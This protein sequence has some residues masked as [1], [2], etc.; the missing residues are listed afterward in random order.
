MKDIKTKG[1]HKGIETNEHS[2]S[3]ASKM[4]QGLM[5]SG[6][7]VKNYA[8]DGQ[9]TPD[10][11]AQDNVRYMAEKTADDI[12]H[13][14]ES[15]A[16]KTYSAGKKAIS[17]IKQRRMDEKSIKQTAKSTGKA[18]IKTVERNIKTAERAAVQKTVK[19]SEKAAKTAYQT[20]KK[21]EKSAKA[22]AKAAKKS[23]KNAKKAAEKT[24]EAVKVAAK[25]IAAVV[26]KIYK[27]LKAL[28]LLIAA[29]GWVS[30]VVIV[31]IAVIAL[32]ACTGYGIFFTGEEIENSYTL[33]EAV[34]EINM[35]YDYD[36]TAIL[37]NT[38]YDVVEMRGDRA[39]WRD[40][41]AV[42]AVKTSGNKDDPQE[43]V[44]MDASKSAILKTVFWDM[45]HVEYRTEV[46]NDI[47]RIETKDDNGHE[48]VKEATVERIHLIIN[49]SHKS[50]NEMADEYRFSESQREQLRDLT[51]EKNKEIWDSLLSDF[52]GE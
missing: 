23:A 9:I 4:K 28:V 11:Y 34:A 6:N 24:A 38:E 16:R 30:V 42:Y 39:P 40:V 13:V 2:S 36:M 12:V 19:S 29:G 25:V 43:V 17:R 7:Q 26:K 48:V 45:N 50:V 49:E 37:E 52:P 32:I 10:E 44:T 31:V 5:R 14:T 21:S 51:S 20:V 35:E 27:G 33:Q 46:K 15:S 18:T 22:A 8:D 3:L 47:I 41:L 1:N